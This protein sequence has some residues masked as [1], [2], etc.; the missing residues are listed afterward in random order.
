MFVINNISANSQKLYFNNCALWAGE[1]AHLLKT[2]AQNQNAMDSVIRSRI[3]LSGQMDSK[4]D[5]S[6]Y[7][8]QSASS[9]QAGQQFGY[10]LLLKY[11]F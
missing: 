3:F 10:I 2:K 4:G 9:L 11:D 6:I 7:S 5:S 8:S 1:V